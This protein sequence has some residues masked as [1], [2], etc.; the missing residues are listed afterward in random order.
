MKR[1]ADAALMKKLEAYNARRAALQGLLET[2]KRVAADPRK[3]SREHK[4]WECG[5]M[6]RD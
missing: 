1:G 4:N 6:S 5:V 3:A 2:S